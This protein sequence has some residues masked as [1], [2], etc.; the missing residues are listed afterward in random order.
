MCHFPFLYVLWH[1]YLPW[2]IF[3]STSINFNLKLGQGFM[4]YKILIIDDDGDFTL[5]FA[6]EVRQLYPDTVVLS[7]ENGYRAFQILKFMLPEV[8]DVLFVDVRMPI[9]D[10]HE[11]V[12]EI[13]E[14]QEFSTVPIV[15]Y[16]AVT[17]PDEKQNALQ[18][19]ATH[20]FQKPVTR[21][22]IDDMIRAVIANSKR[23]A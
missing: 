17:N 20:Y 8:P 22:K 7:A 16:S 5:L 13:R 11:I 18:C 15:M 14:R 4:G 2:K 3:S 12:K 19:G 21:D 6:G 10:G 23:V 9:M 1:T